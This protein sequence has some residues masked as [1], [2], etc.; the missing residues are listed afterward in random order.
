MSWLTLQGRVGVIQAVAGGKA[1]TP[2]TMSRTPDKLSR[3][4]EKFYL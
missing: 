1:I 2:V 4:E 3:C